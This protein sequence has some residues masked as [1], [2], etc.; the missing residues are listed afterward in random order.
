MQ[1]SRHV[2]QPFVYKVRCD[3]VGYLAVCYHSGFQNHDHAAALDGSFGPYWLLSP[4][5]CPI[6][7]PL[8]SYH[9]LSSVYLRESSAFIPVFAF[10]PCGHSLHCSYL[11]ISL[12]SIYNSPSKCSVWMGSQPPLLDGSPSSLSL[13]WS[14]AS[15][16]QFLCLPK[17]LLRDT[18][19]VWGTLH[20]PQGRINSL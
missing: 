2:L 6:K 8:S 1:C 12:Q 15:F 10:L 4:F 5:R 17:L 9:L 13:R 3:S 14:W 18:R 16:S 7:C 11:K 19:R 20:F